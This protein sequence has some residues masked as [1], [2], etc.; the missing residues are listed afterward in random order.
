[1]FNILLYN[2][3]VLKYRERVSFCK[4]HIEKMAFL[5]TKPLSFTPSHF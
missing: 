3:Y 1:M 2:V 5:H 4:D